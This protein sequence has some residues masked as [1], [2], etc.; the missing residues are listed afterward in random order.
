MKLRHMIEEKNLDTYIRLK[1]FYEKKDFSTPRS[2]N[3]KKI[4]LEIINELSES[5]PVANT[6]SNLS[7]NYLETFNQ[8]DSQTN[9]YHSFIDRMHNLLVEIIEIA[10]KN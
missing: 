9:G 5:N 8:M 3:E 10:Q 7:N 6:L 2:E 1:D 4:E